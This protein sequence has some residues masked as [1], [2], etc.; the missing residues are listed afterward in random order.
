SAVVVLVLASSGDIDVI[1]KSKTARA[2]IAIFY[3]FFVQLFPIRAQRR[4]CYLEIKSNAEPQIPLPIG[5]RRHQKVLPRQLLRRRRI[6]AGADK[7]YVLGPKAEHC[8]VQ[9]VPDL[10]IRPQPKTLTETPLP[11]YPQ[12]KDEQ[13]RADACV[14]R[15]IPA[16]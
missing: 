15:Q 6:F 3:T 4:F 13:A 1:T 7:I 8:H 2:S 11:R 5:P 9:H 10:N 12:V 14:P 16:L